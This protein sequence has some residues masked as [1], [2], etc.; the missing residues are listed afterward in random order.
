MRF[1]SYRDPPQALKYYNRFYL[2]APPSASIGRPKEDTH[3]LQPCYIV[4]Y[5]K[6]EC[7]NQ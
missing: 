4:S 1:G 5:N 3:A 2:Y 7:R 6:M